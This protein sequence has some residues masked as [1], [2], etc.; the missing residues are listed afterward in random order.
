MDKNLAAIK[1]EAMALM[2]SSGYPIFEEVVFEV[3]PRL[4]IMGYTTDREGKT[5]IVVSGWSL[6]T[7]MLTGLLIHELSHVYRTET[8][9]PSHNFSL[10]R[11]VVRKVMGSKRL[12]DDKKDALHNVIN[13][14]QDIYADDISFDVYFRKHHR[15]NLSDFF[16]AWVHEPEDNAWK[17]AEHLVSAAFAAANLKRHK[18]SDE[19]NK[20]TMA[21]QKFLGVIENKMAG[22]FDYFEREMTKL[23]ENISEQEFEIW[24]TNFLERFVSLTEI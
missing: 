13:N 23:P 11:K 20:V 6:R 7:P 4:E 3:D 2:R 24:L 12:S 1:S 15:G 5:L 9:H 8:F 22:E 18:V 10:H 16:L 14:I 21:V 17:N 19:G